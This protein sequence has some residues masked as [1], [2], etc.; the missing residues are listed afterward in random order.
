MKVP[1]DQIADLPIDV[2]FLGGKIVYE[3][4]GEAQTGVASPQ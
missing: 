3:N 1:E 2:T 4:K